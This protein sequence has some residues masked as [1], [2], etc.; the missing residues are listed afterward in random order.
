[1]AQLFP[2]DAHPHCSLQCRLGL[3]LPVTP[4]SILPLPLPPK[5]G[6]HELQGLMEKYELNFEFCFP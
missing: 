4:T 6:L 2:N 1:M 3:D 5:R